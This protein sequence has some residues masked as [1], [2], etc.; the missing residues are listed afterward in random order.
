[1]PDP[2]TPG[3][4]PSL[5]HVEIQGETE[6]AAGGSLVDGGGI[7]EKPQCG[8]QAQSPEEQ[9]H[10]QQ[11]H[12]R[13]KMWPQFPSQAVPGLSRGT[14]LGTGPAGMGSTG[15]ALSDPQKHIR[16]CREPERCRGDGCGWSRAGDRRWQSHGDGWGDT[17]TA[18][19]AYGP[20]R[21]ARLRVA[22]SGCS[23]W[24]GYF[25][26]QAVPTSGNVARKGE[27]KRAQGPSIPPISPPQP[28]GADSS[29]PAR[30][31]HHPCSPTV[32][33]SLGRDTPK[34]ARGEAAVQG[35]GSGKGAGAG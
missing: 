2:D 27:D 28:D 24:G 8:G 10:P 1:M 15:R 26:V 29:E 12:R 11:P 33:P 6:I 31:G 25:G 23:S 7:L 34:P 19:I 32:S 18:A 35:N 4:L 13:P 17:V 3:L 14:Q 20:P 30:T 16:F 21:G 22:I 5:T 9:Q